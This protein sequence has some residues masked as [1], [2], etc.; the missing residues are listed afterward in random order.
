MDPLAKRAES[1]PDINGNRKAGGSS[2]GLTPECWQTSLWTPMQTHVDSK[3]ALHSLTVIS[4]HPSDP[5]STPGGGGTPESLPLIA[6]VMEAQGN[7]EAS[8]TIVGRVT[9]Q[10]WGVNSLVLPTDTRL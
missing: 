9:W 8:P 5:Q 4:F 7:E 10:A 3:H 6:N 1:Q 2:D